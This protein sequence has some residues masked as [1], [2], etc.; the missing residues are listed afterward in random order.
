MT[1]KIAV[2]SRREP[3]LVGVRLALENLAAVPWPATGATLEAFDIPSGAADTPIGDLAI[4][5]GARRRA[6]GALAAM[7][8]DGLG[9]GLEGGVTVLSRRPLVVVLRN[10]TVA[11]DG[12]TEGLGASPSVQLPAALARAVF[13]GEDLAAAIDRLVGDHDVRSRQGTFG[14]LTRD[15]I[16]RADAFALSVVAALAPWYN[17]QARTEGR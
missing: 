12:T 7:G 11:W 4:I 3:K 13:G 1:L 2:G 10:W 5:A 15:L 14:V 6:H 17:S 8:G 9:L 16:T